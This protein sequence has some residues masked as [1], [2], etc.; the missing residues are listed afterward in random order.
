M[1]ADGKPTPLPMDPLG[2]AQAVNAAATP[3]T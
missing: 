3:R 1:S 2:E